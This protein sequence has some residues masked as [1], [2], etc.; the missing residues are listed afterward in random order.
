M[1]NK[2]FGTKRGNMLRYNTMIQNVNSWNKANY[3]DYHILK[4]SKWKFEFTGANQILEFKFYIVP[5]KNW[6]I[7]W[8]EQKFHWFWVEDRSSSWGLLKGKL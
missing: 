3:N 4:S 2:Y 7:Y 1:E 5:N 6:K 8:S